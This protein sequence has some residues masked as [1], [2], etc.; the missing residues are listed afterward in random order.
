MSGLGGLSGNLL[1][2]R[3]ITGFD[4]ERKEGQTALGSM[5]AGPCP[6][7]RRGLPSEMAKD[8]AVPSWRAGIDCVSVGYPRAANGMNLD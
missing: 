7:Y 8:K 6:F 1:L 2:D 5:A 4:P 3:S